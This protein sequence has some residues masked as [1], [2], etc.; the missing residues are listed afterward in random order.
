[1]AAIDA[2]FGTL[3]GRERARSWFRPRMHALMH[4]T[5]AF[6]VFL[7][8]F[9]IVEPSPYEFGFV[10]VLLTLIP[11]GLRL[12]RS[13]LPILLLTLM[14]VP[15]AVIAAFQATFMS[16]VQALVFQLVTFFL[17]LTAYVAANYI[18]EA[19]LERMR[20]M[21]NVYTLTA[22][23]SAVVG[24]A[25]YLH[26][27]PGGYDLFTRYGRA[28]AFFQDPNV[29]GPFLI[30]PA[31]YALQRMFFVRGRAFYVAA[32]IVMVLFIGVF[33][34]FSRAA[35]G[36]F[37]AAALITFVLVFTL[38]SNAFTKTRM[39]L[40]TMAGVLALSLTLGGLLS[41]PSVRSLFNERAEV[42]QS[43][44]SGSTGRFG[45]QSYAYDL[46][47]NNPLGIGPGQFT[48]LR[49]IEEPHDVYVNVLHVYGWGGGLAYYLLVVATLWRGLSCL[50]KR[51]P[52]RLLLIPLLATFVPLVIEGAIID[53]DH[54]RHYYLIVGMIWGIASGYSLRGPDTQRGTSALV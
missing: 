47:L 4:G 6:W 54:W 16:T 25:G 22:V 48:H 3:D 45:R 35:W 21:V 27:I 12:Y 31:M 38:E 17:M 30:L 5:I 13:T 51:S 23:I 53:L 37:L 28:K 2:G 41:I 34:S 40:L 36:S 50:F 18:A 33:V 49:V 9:V 10:L 26:L 42:E 7:G 24:T 46:A 52:N 19:P 43:Y 44:D 39:L 20:R 32:A 29:F 11:G 8:S 1:M 15:F 14:F